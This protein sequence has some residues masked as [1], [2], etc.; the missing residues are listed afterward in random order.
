MVLL[1]ANQ[2]TCEG[3]APP[4]EVEF[5]WSKHNAILCIHLQELIHVVEG[6]TNTMVMKECVIHT[7]QLPQNASCCVVKVLHEGIRHSS[8]VHGDASVVGGVLWHNESGQLAALLIQGVLV[9][10]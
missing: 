9:V 1:P 3:H 8:V 5:V 4:A 10:F 6:F 2:V 7:L